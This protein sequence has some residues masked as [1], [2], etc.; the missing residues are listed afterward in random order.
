MPAVA[1][2]SSRLV[3]IGDLNAAYDALVEILLGTK[4]INRRLQ[5]IGGRAELVE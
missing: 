5:W 1:N 3:V 2:A 4:L